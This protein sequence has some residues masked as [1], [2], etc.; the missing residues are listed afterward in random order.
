MLTNEVEGSKLKCHRYW[1]RQID[2]AAIYG[3]M[4]VRLKEELES[5]AWKTRTFT[6]F[7]KKV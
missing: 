7:N 3:N 2:E 4:E 5:T 6:L 1:A